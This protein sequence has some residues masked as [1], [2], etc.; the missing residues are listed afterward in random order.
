MLRAFLKYGLW[1]LLGSLILCSFSALQKGIVG[2]PFHLKGFFVP[3]LF[4][5]LCGL[6]L[7]FWR[8]KWRKSSTSLLE[9]EQRYR[10][11]YENAPVMLHSIDPHGRL[12]TV[13]NFWLETLGYSP[14]EVL[15]RKLTDFMTESSRQLAKQTI[16]PMFFRTGSVKY[17]PYQ[18]VKKNGEI[19]EVLLSAIAERSADGHIERSLAVAIDVTEHRQAEQEVK[20]LAYYDTLTGLPNRTLFQD[21]LGQALAHARRNNSKVEVLFLDLDRFKG[22]NDTLGHAIGDE[23]L[24]IIAQR[25]KEC[26]RRG[27]TVA[28]LGGDEF[29][30]VLSSYSGDQDGATFAERVLETLAQPVKLAGG[31]LCSTASIGISIYPID[32]QDID[33]LLRNADIAM[34]AAKERG[35]N[36][37]QFFSDEMNTR[38]VEKLGLETSLRRA[39]DRGE[40]FLFYQPQIDIQSGRIIGVES[41]LRW[42]HPQEGLIPPEKF[43]PIAEETGL[44]LSIG[45]W[46]LRTACKQAREWQ[47]AG[48]TPIRMAVNL[49]ARQFKQANV[50]DMVDRV[51]EET[52]LDPKW[53]ELEL[54]ESLIMDNTVETI[55]ALTD[56]KVRGIHLA[57]DDFGTGYSS[58]AYLKNFPIDRIKIAQEFVHGLPGDGD[59]EAIVEAIIAMGKSLKLNVLAEGVENLEQLEFLTQRHCHEVQ[60]FYFSRPCTAPEIGELFTLGMSK[61]GFCLYQDRPG[62]SLH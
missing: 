2:I 7:N 19:V 47:I 40:L 41:L 14:Q 6:L 24:K 48:H 57:I 12:L 59:S 17:I 29:V 9:S 42:R 15:G 11:L 61:A 58:L 3:L 28:R 50:I 39:L 27:D 62:Q 22:I 5:G 26:M 32:G 33:T 31:E 1:F 43:I 20:K 44:I 8:E 4:G 18:L 35:R 16:F 34:Y 51:L 37:Y 36:N 45:E 10:S 30:I 52:G 13:S 55:M 25:L 46:A 23:F 49:S 38:V 53:L 56:I 60:G 21:R 54:T